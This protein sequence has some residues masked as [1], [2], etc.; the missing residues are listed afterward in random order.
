MLAGALVL[1]VCITAFMGLAV[2]FQSR[3]SERQVAAIVSELVP[4][5]PFSIGVSRLGSPSRKLTNTDEIRVFSPE[6]P[7]GV[8]DDAPLYL[9][10]HCGPPFRWVLIYT[11]RDSQVIRHAKWQ[12]M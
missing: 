10:V 12:S 4:G 7:P 9:F 5:T 11:D 3:R 1:V 6:A 2:E 8:G